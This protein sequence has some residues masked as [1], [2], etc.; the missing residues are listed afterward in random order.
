MGGTVGIISPAVSA[1]SQGGPGSTFWFTLPLQVASQQ[2]LPLQKIA[3]GNEKINYGGHLQVLMAEDNVVNQRLAKLILQEAGCQV[4]IAGNGQE[5]LDLVQKQYFDI[6]FMDLQMPVMDGYTATQQ[7]RSLNINLPIVGLSANVYKEDIDQCYQ[8]GMND[9]LSKPYSAKKLLQKLQK[10]VN[11]HAF[12]RDSSALS[13]TTTESKDSQID[14]KNME[15]LTGG[16]WSEMKEMIEAVLVVEKE[17]MAAL[18]D[19]LLHRNIV[20]LAASAHKLKPCLYLVGLDNF[21]EKLEKLENQSKKEEDTEEIAQLCM[22]LKIVFT[23]AEV[24]LENHLMHY[25]S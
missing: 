19:W 23:Q 1:H 4:T 16:S 11:P 18:N 17:F 15:E 20:M 5:A 10:W 22:E 12:P 14:L 2:E 21:R 9:Y 8:A 13:H 6:V 3:A 7:I 25:S 24:E